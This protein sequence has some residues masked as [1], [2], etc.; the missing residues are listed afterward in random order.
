MTEHITH[1]SS[2]A[3]SYLSVR[4]ISTSINRGQQASKQSQIP[5]PPQIPITTPT[6]ISNIA[7][8]PPGSIDTASV[9]KDAD[10]NLSTAQ[11]QRKIQTNLR[12]TPLPERLAKSL[13]GVAKGATETYITYGLTQSL[14]NSCAAQAGYTIPEEQRQGLYTGQGP[15]TNSRQEHVGVPDAENKLCKGAD[16]WWF[17]ELGLEPTFSVWSQV[18]FLHLYM[19]TVRMR[20]LPTNKEYLE[21]QKYLLEHFSAEAEDRMSL[22]HGMGGSRTVRNKYLKDLFT[23]WRGV[24]YAYDEGL[25][26]GDAVLATAVWRNLWKADEDVEWEKV[27]LVVAYLRRSLTSLSRMSLQEITTELQ[28]N[29][30]FW[31]QAQQGLSA[32]VSE[33]A[34]KINSQPS[35]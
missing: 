19:L 15:P 20:D 9:K 34:K 33:K 11:M 17:K 22:W 26:K 3:K 32:V 13:R 30:Q 16:S 24:V 18:T 25:V 21:H 8:E 23:Q 31:E 1:I 29:S 7:A 5:I 28:D 2:Q 27:A 35:L 4:A 12:G 6:A 14:L 10:P